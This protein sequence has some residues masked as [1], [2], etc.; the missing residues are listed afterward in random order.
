MSP[1]SYPARAAE[2]MHP[3]LL[4]GLQRHVFDTEGQRTVITTVSFSACQ[5]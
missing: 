3:P 4:T 5:W 2:G 1:L